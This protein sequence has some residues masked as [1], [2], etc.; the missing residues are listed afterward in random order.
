[1]SCVPISLTWR[2]D[3]NGG[4]SASTT[5]GNTGEH[6]PVGVHPEVRSN[7]AIA[8]HIGEV[9]QLLLGFMGKVRLEMIIDPL[10]RGPGLV[11]G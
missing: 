6:M 10:S 2:Y 7:S 8:K 5:C 11:Q 9:Q 1:M 3:S 4:S